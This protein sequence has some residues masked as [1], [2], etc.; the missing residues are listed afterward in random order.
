MPP[1]EQAANPPGAEKH[2]KRKRKVPLFVYFINL[3]MLAMIMLLTRYL[4]RMTRRKRP[5]NSAVVS[6]KATDQ[7]SDRE[8][9]PDPLRILC[10]HGHLT[11][12]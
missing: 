9:G 4:W 11:V 2:S 6:D 3:P 8:V 5:N 7:V 10:V 1:E 12:R